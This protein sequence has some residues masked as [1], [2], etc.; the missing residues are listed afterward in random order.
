MLVVCHLASYLNIIRHGFLSETSTPS[1]HE[2][3]KAKASHL[4]RSCRS[5]AESTS[6]VNWIPKGHRE[7]ES[8]RELMIAE[9]WD[10]D[11]DYDG[12]EED[13]HGGGVVSMQSFFKD[14]KN[15]WQL[16]GLKFC[17]HIHGADWNEIMQKYYDHMGWG[18]YHPMEEV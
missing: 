17:C 11:E 15:K 10:I 13:T 2:A 3:G 8:H 14:P 4:F 5:V 12:P 18:T 1:L 9:H 7:F 16:V 6:F